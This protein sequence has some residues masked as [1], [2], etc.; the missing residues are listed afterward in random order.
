[1]QLSDKPLIWCGDLNVR[2]AFFLNL[3]RLSFFCSGWEVVIA[4]LSIV[5][6]HF[7]F[8]FLCFDYLAQGSSC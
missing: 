4:P 1:V 2:L 8:A 5:C 7:S 6:L 3:F